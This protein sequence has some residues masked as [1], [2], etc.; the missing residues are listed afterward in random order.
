MAA[1]FGALALAICA[2]MPV[3]SL[4]DSTRILQRI[5]DQV[6]AQ[7]AQPGR[8]YILGISAATAP[9]G[10]QDERPLEELMHDADK[11]MY[12]AKRRRK[13]HSMGAVR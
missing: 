8:D 6:Q 12:A 2:L 1:S 13:T 3:Q 9:V 7:N 11:S 10:P 4:D 5:Q